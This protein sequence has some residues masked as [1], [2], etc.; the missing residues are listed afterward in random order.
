M[1]RKKLFYLVNCIILIAGMLVKCGYVTL[2]FNHFVISWELNRM[3]AGF[4]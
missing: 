1:R 4:S 2:N 3:F